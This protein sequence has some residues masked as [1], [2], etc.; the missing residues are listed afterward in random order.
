MDV[1]L[2]FDRGDRGP[3]ISRISADG[4]VLKPFA[5]FVLA[6]GSWIFFPQRTFERTGSFHI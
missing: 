2:G 6:S 3:Q 5:E 1:P 4:T